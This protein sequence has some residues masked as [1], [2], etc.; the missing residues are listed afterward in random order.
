MGCRATSTR[1]YARPAR[2][3]A[4]RLSATA[5]LME[6][7]C[8]MVRAQLIWGVAQRHASCDEPAVAYC[9]GSCTALTSSGP[10]S[11]RSRRAASG[12]HE[13]MSTSKRTRSALARTRWRSQWTAARRRS[14]AEA[15]SSASWLLE[16]LATLAACLP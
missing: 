15:F 6:S 1:A 14:G 7:S 11:E 2:S 3:S 10:Q 16:R 13:C 5:R 8:E 4:S 12:L 9:A